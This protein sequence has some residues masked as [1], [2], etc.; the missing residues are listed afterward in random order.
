[1][2]GKKFLS[3]KLDVVFKMLFCDVRNRDILADF[4]G[5]I[6]EIQ[7][8]EFEDITILNPDLEKDFAD[9]KLGVVDL[10]VMTKQKEIIH[11]ELQ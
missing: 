1:M 9:G 4:L 8:E 7:A 5:S 3:P 2:E 11:I 6:L 10:R